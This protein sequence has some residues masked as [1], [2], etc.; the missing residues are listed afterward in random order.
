[1]GNCCNHNQDLGKVYR[2]RS[3][4]LWIVLFINAVMFVVEFTAG[5]RG[6]SISLIGDSLDMLGDT[7]AYG[8]TLYVLRLGKKAQA[9]ASLLKGTIM[10]FTAIIVFGRAFFQLLFDSI[11]DA[12]IMSLIIILALI[13]NLIC[14]LL[15]TKYRKDNINMSS[16]WLCSRNDIIANILV[17]V[18]AG[19]VAL[20]NSLIPDFITGLIIT[21]IF[22]QSANR[23]LF[24][25]F[26][27]LIND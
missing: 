25:S 21:I 6:N 20:T 27:Q 13:M 5:F 15:L 3:L 14:L 22:A 1:M 18:T 9:K 12:K 8:S 19:L 10:L 2:E 17:L 24:E 4:V 7:L 23:V 16:I 26:K 11:P